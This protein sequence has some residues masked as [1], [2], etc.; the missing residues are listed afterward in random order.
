M[1]QD[2][3]NKAESGNKDEVFP[4]RGRGFV[5]RQD[6]W[7]KT[8]EEKIAEQRQ[9]VRVCFLLLAIIF[10]I[11]RKTRLLCQHF[12]CYKIEGKQHGVKDNNAGDTV[13][14]VCGKITK[15]HP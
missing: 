4:Q 1:H 7:N 6:E 2:G 10:C 12:F 8:G 11:S 5:R 14:S 13:N 3:N 15:C 9:Y